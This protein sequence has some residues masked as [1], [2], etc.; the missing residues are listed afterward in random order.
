MEV[1][2]WVYENFDDLSG[3]S[4]LPFSEHTYVQAPY[5]DITKE[6]YDDMLAKMPT[7]LDWTKLLEKTDNTE[8]SQTLACVGPDGC[9]I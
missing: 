9:E 2:S 7:N 4:F 5:E 1:G 8:G 3:V 6:Q